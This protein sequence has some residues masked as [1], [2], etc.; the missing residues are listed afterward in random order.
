MRAAA[1]NTV[2]K[3]YIYFDNHYKFI[4]RWRRFIYI[5]LFQLIFII[6]SFLTI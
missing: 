5:S 3:L 2:S 6:C 4:E 1:L